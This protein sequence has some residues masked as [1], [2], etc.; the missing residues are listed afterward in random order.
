MM[1]TR[2]SLTT[3]CQG[4]LESSV[5]HKAFTKRG[6]HAPIGRIPAY[7]LAHILWKKQSMSSSEERNFR[8]NLGKNRLL[9]R[10]SDQSIVH[11]RRDYNL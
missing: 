1:V 3:V 9:R 11:Q 7:Q 6:N 5:R 8:K 2:S 4:Q 10:E